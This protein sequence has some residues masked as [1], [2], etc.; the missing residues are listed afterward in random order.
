MRLLVISATSLVDHPGGGFLS[1][2]IVLIDNFELALRADNAKAKDA[3]NE[4]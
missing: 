2:S 3:D 4:T 1:G